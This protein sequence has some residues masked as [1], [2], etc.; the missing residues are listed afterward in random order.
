M[1]AAGLSGTGKL[2]LGFQETRDQSFELVS[3]GSDQT[4]IRLIHATSHQEFRGVIPLPVI[5]LQT[6]SFRFS[7]DVLRMYLTAN[8]PDLRRPI[9]LDRFPVIPD[10][11]CTGCPLRVPT[12]CQQSPC[13]CGRCVPCRHCSS[14]NEIQNRV[15]QI[16]SKWKQM[17]NM[18]AQQ[19]PFNSKADFQK[20]R[21]ELSS[22]LQSWRYMRA[23]TVNPAAWPPLDTNLTHGP[24]LLRM[25]DDT[26]LLFP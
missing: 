5:D 25:L 1:A 2:T 24:D 3:L 9:Y 12:I 19:P 18:G 17:V 21:D 23:V 26:L 6:L 11:V 15:P 10:P 4:Q 16:I 8:H 20:L 7:D 22:G 14:W 13:Q